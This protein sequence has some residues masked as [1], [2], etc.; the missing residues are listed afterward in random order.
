[1]NPESSAPVYQPPSEIEPQGEKPKYVRHKSR[2]PGILQYTLPA[3]IFAS[4][5]V[6]IY[7]RMQT[8]SKVQADLAPVAAAANE[9]PVAVVRPQLSDPNQTITLPGNVQAFV[10]TPIYARTS[11][12][13]TKWYVDIGG[14]VKAGDLLALIDTPEVDQQLRQAE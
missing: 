3:L 10:E 14:R 4:F 9:L 7:W 8:R 2:R 12:Y 5:A 1:M 13:L 11:G 6:L